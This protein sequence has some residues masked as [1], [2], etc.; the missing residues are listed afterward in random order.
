MSEDTF[1]RGVIGL[2]AIIL[3]TGVMSI[4]TITGQVTFEQTEVFAGQE[5][6]SIG[7][8]AHL[9]IMPEDA[10][11]EIEVHGPDGRLVANGL[12]FFV[13]KQGAYQVTAWITA[14]NKTVERQTSFI[15]EAEAGL[16]VQ[17]EMPEPAPETVEESNGQSAAEPINVTAIEL[18]EESNKEN[19]ENSN[20]S[21]N[22]IDITANVSI[23]P[24]ANVSTPKNATNTSLA[25]G[26]IT[27]NETEQIKKN[28]TATVKTNETVDINTTK[29]PTRQLKK[30]EKSKV[31]NITVHF[32]GADIY[33]QEE[34]D[35]HGRRKT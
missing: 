7:D 12:N 15:S 35:E 32:S 18:D 20:Q 17:E 22:T 13:E 6:Y 21:A 19:N 27:L 28:Q 1:R 4:L 30:Q 11:Y 33:E 8:M 29:A 23:I 2:I 5:V 16:P 14:N 31:R 25:A 34:I 10:E 9:F 24:A 3:A 26:V